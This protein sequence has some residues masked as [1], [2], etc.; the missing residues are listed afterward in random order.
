VHAWHGGNSGVDT[1][2]EHP[3]DGRRTAVGAGVATAAVA[4]LRDVGVASMG[5]A[6]ALMARAWPL[7]HVANA[8]VD[9]T[10]ARGGR[11]TRAPATCRRE[12]AAGVTPAAA[13]AR[14]MRA[15]MRAVPVLV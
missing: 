3:G 11:R 1:Y 10:A 14:A 2:G 4:A 8:A 9:G 13:I 5:A 12:C 7:R 6:A 15:C